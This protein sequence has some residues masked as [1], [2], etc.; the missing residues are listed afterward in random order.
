MILTEVRAANLLYLLQLRF[1]RKHTYSN[2]YQ[3]STVY[4][5]QISGSV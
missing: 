5:G 2:L 4:L 1:R 3:E